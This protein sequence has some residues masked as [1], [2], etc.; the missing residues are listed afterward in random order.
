MFGF[1][2]GAAGTKVSQE[3]E[4]GRDLVVC[5]ACGAHFPPAMDTLEARGSPMVSF[6]E[7]IDATDATDATDAEGPPKFEG[8][9]VSALMVEMTDCVTMTV[10]PPMMSS[11]L[12][13]TSP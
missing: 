11:L 2:V 10:E 8:V 3:V 6:S 9:K 1:L 12:L 7:E 4:S 5:P 13:Q